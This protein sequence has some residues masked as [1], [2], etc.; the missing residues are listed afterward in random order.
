MSPT[1]SLES[2]FTTL[3]IDAH[4]ERNVA[5]FDIPRAYLHADM[6]SDKNMILKLRGHFVDIMYDINGEYRQ[7]VR[8][9]QQ[10][11]C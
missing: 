1:L 8:Y 5:T 10:N 6:P 9:E 7:Y 3:V 11:V 4:E 2:L